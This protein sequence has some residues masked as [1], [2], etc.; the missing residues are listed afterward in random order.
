MYTL[1]ILSELF[2]KTK[3]SQLE[4]FIDP[5][6]MTI[7]RFGIDANYVRAAAFIAQIGH[8]SGGLNFVRENLNY[9]KDGLLKIFPKYFTEQTAA[10][11][12]RNPPAI[13][14]KVYGGR[15]GNGDESSQEGWKFSGR[16]LIQ[17]TGKNNYTRFAADMGMS[18]DEAVEYLETTEGAAMSAGWFWDVSKLN[19][20][21]DSGDFVLLTKR[22]NG[23]TIGLADRQHHYDVALQLL[24]Q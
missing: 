2:P 9:S 3:Q 6:N 8:E 20:I 22:I 5:L 4:K 17:L 13:A 24:E 1:S 16:G 15:M 21:A 18:L 10:Q 7:Q 11:Y 23:G 14:S 19:S 12:A